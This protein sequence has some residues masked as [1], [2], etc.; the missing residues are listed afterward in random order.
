MCSV[1]SHVPSH[2][3]FFHWSVICLSF[4]KSTPVFLQKK[5]DG[6]SLI[7]V[8]SMV[9]TALLVC[10]NL[11]EIDWKIV[12]CT[13][14]YMVC[15]N[16][17]QMLLDISHQLAKNLQ[18]YVERHRETEDTPRSWKFAGAA[19]WWSIQLPWWPLAYLTA[20][21]TSLYA[22]SSSLSSYLLSKTKD[23]DETSTRYWQDLWI[24]V[25]APKLH[26]HVNCWSL[27][28]FPLCGEA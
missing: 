12:A 7:C 21:N 28:Q 23:P 19:M 25:T 27:L 10:R 8:K 20:T 18:M 16:V 13:F 4:Q 22:F 3:Q 11:S 17:P 6:V 14:F 1:V 2:R 24:L 15:V 9:S 5:I 26:V